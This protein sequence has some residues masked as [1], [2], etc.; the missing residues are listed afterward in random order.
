MLP[1]GGEGS[2]LGKLI[3]F[4][5]LTPHLNPPPHFSLK[6]VLCWHARLP[7]GRGVCSGPVSITHSV[8]HRRRGASRQPAVINCLFGLLLWPRREDAGQLPRLAWAI[9]SGSR[10]PCSSGHNHPVL[11]AQAGR[12]LGST[13]ATSAH[14]GQSQ[15]CSV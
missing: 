7:L 4:N 1:G 6:L 10:S 12:D 2:E 15:Q 3:V 8:E 13:E 11:N 14:F 9:E 5:K